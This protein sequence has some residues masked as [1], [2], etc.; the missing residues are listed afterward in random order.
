MSRRPTRSPLPTAPSA[1]GG[2]AVSPA[3]WSPVTELGALIAADPHTVMKRDSATPWV[4][5]S[6]GR[7]GTKLGDWL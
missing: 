5:G 7:R 6:K 1:C 3:F 4:A 2:P